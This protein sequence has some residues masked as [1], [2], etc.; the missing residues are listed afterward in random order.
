MALTKEIKHRHTIGES[1]HIQVTEITQILEDGD[2][3][4]ETYHK[5]VISPGDDTENETGRTQKIASAVHDKD[6][7]DAHN[8][9]V[10]QLK[11]V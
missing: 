7:V 5:K 9:R 8:A 3:I 11:K 1:G 6:C 4:A 10:A 2:V